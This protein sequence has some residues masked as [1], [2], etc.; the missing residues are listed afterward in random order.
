M[1]TSNLQQFA[2]HEAQ[3]MVASMASGASGPASILFTMEKLR[4]ASWILR[5]SNRWDLKPCLHA[6]YA[7]EGK[8]QQIGEV[9][10]AGRSGST[11]NDPTEM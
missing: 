5:I 9:F 10:A 6:Q 4:G 2:L 3:V 7:C 1:I 8:E 11:I